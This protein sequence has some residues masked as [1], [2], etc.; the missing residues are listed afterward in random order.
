M[1]T[2]PQVVNISIE[3]GTDYTLSLL[4]TDLST[5]LP[6]NITSYTA[7][8]QVRATYD[9]SSP[10][11]IE[12]STALANIILGGST[13]TIDV[14]FT[15]ADTL[16]LLWSKAMYDLLLTSPGGVITKLVKGEFIVGQTVSILPP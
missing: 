5:N 16:N 15:H 14:L 3:E 4:W 13:G 10:T 1:P 8:L 6:K 2:I 9:L 11:L 12:K 7:L